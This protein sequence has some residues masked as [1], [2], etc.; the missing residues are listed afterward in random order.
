[1]V[2][3]IGQ[4][5]ILH[6]R[7]RL[8]FPAMLRSWQDQQ[9]TACSHGWYSTATSLT[10]HILHRARKTKLSRW[11]TWDLRRLFSFCI[12]FNFCRAFSRCLS[13]SSLFFRSLSKR[14]R[15]FA[16]NKNQKMKHSFVQHHCKISG[17]IHF[18]N[19]HQNKTYNYESQC[20]FHIV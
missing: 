18:I 16:T 5:H 15:N 14:L 20:F 4:L 3:L 12:S 10:R 8:D 11:A 9:N 6:V 19:M 7:A 13:I 2:V 17:N 1:M